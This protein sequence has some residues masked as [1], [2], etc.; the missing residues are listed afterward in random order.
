M[1]PG[2]ESLVLYKNQPAVIRQ[3]ADKK[4]TIE[5]A[6]GQ[7][8]S[9]RPKDVSLIHPGPSPHPRQL[10]TVTGDIQTAWELLDGGM[11]TVE[12]LAELAFGSFTP[13]TAW[14]AWQ[15]VADGVYFDGTPDE[16]SVHSPE[17]VGQI[18]NA[19]QAKATEEQAWEEFA[20]RAAGGHVTLDDERH[21]TDVIALAL[22]RSDSSRTLRR[23]GLPQTPESA[24]TLLLSIGRWLPAD[25]PYPPRLGVT[26]EQPV[27]PIGPLPEEPRHD[28]T[29][30]I[31]LAIDDEGSTDPDDAISLDGERVWIHVADVASLVKPDSPADL[32]A[33]G[34]A[35]NLYLPE[36]TIHMLPDELTERLALGLQPVS[37]ALSIALAPLADGDFE[38][39]EVLPTWVQV[40]RTTYESAETQLEQPPYADLLT[41]AGRN[42]RR[43][44]QG[45]AVEI[46]L[47]EVKIKAA[48]DGSVVIRPLPPLRS[49][50]MVR[51][52]M[53]M[54]GEAIG[55]FGQATAI[56]L[57]YTVQDPP[58]VDESLPADLTGVT[59]SVMW[60]QRRLMQRSRPSTSPGRH[61]GLG[62]DVYVQVTSPLRRY[63]D[64]LAHQQVR[65]YLSGETTLDYAAIPLRIGTAD[66]MAGAVRAAERL[67]NQHWTLVYL[68]QHM[69]WQGE[70]IV[71]ENKPGRDVVLIPE[72]A[73]ET[74]IYRRP[75]RPLD[76]VVNLALEAVDLPNKNARFRVI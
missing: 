19:R 2:I 30:L 62:L 73:W 26:T 35:A 1:N 40:T 27:Y 5:L 14:T 29:N 66:A 12:E 37:P 24:H 71:V 17:Q 18:Q 16:V 61:S 41:I 34:R 63:L 52:L 32:E 49:R 39:L 3:F 6:D 8:V 33:R 13:A 48:V 47:P 10:K 58:T 67:S 50:E 15:L 4:L 75:P 25:N 72:L 9:V 31:A 69:D 43:R 22:G 44:I 7:V 38:F 70:G 23:L 54:A 42:R 56:A 11:T 53:L 60:A 21:L 74:E 57:A 36:G 76:S 55:R 65:A 59:A 68:M 51:E 46:E 28:L 64:L 45:G 20:T